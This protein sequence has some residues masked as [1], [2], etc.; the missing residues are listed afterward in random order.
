MLILSN[1]ADSW[2]FLLYTRGGLQCAFTGDVCWSFRTSVFST[3]QK[4][5]MYNISTCSMD[6]LVSKSRENRRSLNTKYDIFLC[7]EKLKRSGS[8]ELPLHLK[9]IVSRQSASVLTLTLHW[10]QFCM[11]FYVLRRITV[12][13]NTHSILHIIGC[14]QSLVVAY[15]VLL[16]HTNSL[17][18]LTPYVV[19]RCSFPRHL[20]DCV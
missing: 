8:N 9:V 16:I 14:Y 1:I 17:S 13:Y 15:F 18:L 11:R 20:L 3:G 12:L 6:T 19:T 4:T 10:L 7:V 2:T 5:R